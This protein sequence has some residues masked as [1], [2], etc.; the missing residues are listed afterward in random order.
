MF[1]SLACQERQI[2]GNSN[3]SKHLIKKPLQIYFST[4]YNFKVLH[5]PLRK[6]NIIYKILLLEILKILKKW[7]VS[8]VIKFQFTRQNTTMD[9]IQGTLL[10]SDFHLVQQEMV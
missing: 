9:L 5:E 2:Q 7:N 6:E 8:L 4:K 1:S 3:D 10:N